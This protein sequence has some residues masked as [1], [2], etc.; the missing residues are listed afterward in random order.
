MKVPRKKSGAGKATRRSAKKKQIAEKWDTKLDM[1]VIIGSAGNKVFLDWLN[2]IREQIASKPYAEKSSFWHKAR[3]R[4]VFNTTGPY[5]MR[6]F[7][8]LPA[9]AFTLQNVKYLDC[10]YFKD[11][12]SLNENR[13]RV[14][15]VISYQSQ[16]YFTK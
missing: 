13:K 8:K 9:N 5:A 15:D 2:Y 12:G 4:Y 3:M 10:I 6:R 1:E 16:S 11:A 14:I 7:L